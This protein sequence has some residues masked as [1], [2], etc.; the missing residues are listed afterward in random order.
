MPIPV[1]LLHGFAGTARHWEGVIAELPEERFAPV[2]LNLSDAEPLTPDGVTRLVSSATAAEPAI[3]VGYS[4]GGRLALH[5]ALAIPDRVARLVLVSASAGIEDPT[6]REA[7][8]VADAA[9]ADEIE[10]NSIESFISRWRSQPLFAHD[11][12][13]VAEEIAADERRCT[14]AGLAAML[15]GLGPGTIAPMWDRLGELTMAVA[16]L[17]GELDPA[18]LLHGQRLAAGA[19]RS[20]FRC[21]PGA[22]HRV[23]LQAPREVA[24]ALCEI[25]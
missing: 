5:A 14:P 10:R 9:L 16:I 3:L 25:G 13:R 4:M 22:G 2:A 19:G 7:R 1:V 21:V 15:R 24:R 23:A 8:R 17:A 18:Y 11:P 20:T 12:E 6:E